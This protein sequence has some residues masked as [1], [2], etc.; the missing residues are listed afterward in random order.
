[1]KALRLALVPSV[2]IACASSAHAFE[3]SDFYVAPMGSYALGD[4]DRPAGDGYGGALAIGAQ[5]GGAVSFEIR[6]QYID[7]GKGN[8]RKDDFGAGGFGFNGYLLG[9][10]SGPYLH[11]DLMGGHEMFYN[12]GLGYELPFGDSGFGLRAEALYHVEDDQKDSG[13]RDFQ[14][15]VFNLGV[16]IPLGSP[17]PPPPPPPPPPEPVVVVPPAA[18][19]SDGADNDGDG[20]IDFPADKG[21]TAADD[22][23]EYNLL[24]KMPEAGQPV[25]MDGCATG[26]TLVLQG[27]TFEFDKATLTPNAKV[28][29]DSVAEALNKRTDIKVEV[30]GHTDDKGSDQYNIG[31]SDRRSKSVKQYL[32]SKGVAG[33]RMTSKGY[34]E[35]MPVA[36]NGTDEGRELNRRVELKVTEASAPVTVAPLAST[37]EST[38]GAPAPVAETPPAAAEP[39]PASGPVDPAPVEATPVAAAPAAASGGS[40]VTIKDFAFAPAALTVPVGTTV[41]WTNNDGS[42]HFVSF[43]DQKS[44]RLKQGAI[45]TR[46]FSAPGT[47]DYACTLHPTMTGKIIVQ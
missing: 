28:I 19:C 18:Q 45:Y 5:L 3:A 33:D 1:M 41:T 38:L 8:G 47:Y 16:R 31:L 43:S 26:D 40:A 23:D 46:T 11:I 2:L 27:V 29:L 36:D 22:N 20:A 37:G 21:C 34:G 10:G 24:C 13:N 32:K 4:D 7:Y 25:N 35:T 6:G 9:A 42:N 39:A 44:P 12:A 17:A 14:D 15:I 30:A